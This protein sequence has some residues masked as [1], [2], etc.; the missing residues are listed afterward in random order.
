MS[1][2]AEAPLPIQ[3]TDA[4][5]NKVKSLI[6]EEENPELKLRV[7][8]TGGGCSGFQY[9]FTFDEKI[10]DGD[11]VVEKNG[12]TMVIDPMSLQ[13]LVGGSVDYTEGLEGSRFTVTN[14]NAT[15]TC[16]CGSSFSI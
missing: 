3:M 4:A 2:V 6:T 11:T 14:P 5:A 10:N 15:T 16:G 8:I 12:V 13:Y 7:Y 9:G 1:A